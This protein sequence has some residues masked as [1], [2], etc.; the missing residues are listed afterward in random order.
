[1]CSLDYIFARLF[2]AT[3]DS[4]V[5]WGSSGF[6]PIFNALIILQKLLRTKLNQ[7]RREKHIGIIFIFRFMD[8]N[9]SKILVDRTQ[10]NSY[11]KF[12]EKSF[13]FLER[14]NT[15]EIPYEK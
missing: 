2:G 15:E 9:I 6:L 12:S 3:G 14:Q 5:V 4:L 13:L 1:M 10:N 7:N 11:I 8:Q